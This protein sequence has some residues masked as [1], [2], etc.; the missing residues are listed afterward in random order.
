MTTPASPVRVRYAPSPTGEPHIG[1]IR[2]AIW[3]WL[4]AQHTGGQFLVRIE[5]TDRTREV[6]GAVGRILE[7]L[8]WLGLTW[9]EGPDIGGPY[10][11]YVQSERL[12]DYHE[13][14]R[15]LIVNDHAYR[16]FCTPD[17]LDEMRK[18]QQ[19]EK[20]SP[21]YEG[22]CRMI[23]PEESFERAASEPFVVRFKVPHEGTTTVEDLLRG[24]IVVEN[25]TLDDFVILKSDGF[26]TY[27]LAH[28][29]D[30]TA[31][32]ITHVTRG[33]EWL[34]S[35]PRHALIFDALGYPRPIYVHNAIILAPG[36]GK[37]SKRHGAK[38][39]LEFAED[40]YLP[41]ALLN[42]LCITGW[43]HG[44]DT[45]MPRKRLIEVFEMA[46]LSLAPATFDIEKLNWM[47]GV[48]L[49][50]MPERDLAELFARRLEIDLP[51]EVPR[52]LDRSF[53]EEF[54][55]LIRERVQLLT[56]V[57][58]LVDFF[59]QHTV[60][61][62]PV[63]QFLTKRWKGEP[64]LA[65]DVLETAATDI[66][67]VD[68]WDP[69][70]LEEILRTTAENAGVKAGD[71]FTLV[72]LAVTGKSVTPPLFESMSIVGSEPSIERVRAAAAAIRASI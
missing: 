30:D 4:F 37:L 43:G 66:D 32:A 7:S 35:A 25:R 55:P 54:T 60:P 9:D 44:D 10:V 52:P 3:S 21:G 70:V 16:C 61:T 65:A 19:A 64:T 39:V 24:P 56:D 38:S 2:T 12:K 53:V 14:A 5:D 13:A 58:P 28:P 48:Y 29:V 47:N 23:T 51:P 49:R 59:Y 27:H 26:P 15:Y 18:R 6:P 1:N 11:P 17:E 40:G 36:G 46:D 62:P 8:R 67:A 69:T 68:P 41:D 33:D 57:L 45:V 22:R 50:D 34:P 72:R 31:M 71:L 42:F 63:E 20:R